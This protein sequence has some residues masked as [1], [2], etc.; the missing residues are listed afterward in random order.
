MRQP[1]DRNGAITFLTKLAE[2]WPRYRELGHVIEQR[3]LRDAEFEHELLV[4]S[5][6]APGDLLR[7]FTGV[8]HI[9]KIAENEVEFVDL[10]GQTFFVTIDVSNTRFRATSM[11][12]ECPACFGE[13]QEP[14]CTICAGVGKV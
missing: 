1:L 6:I 10:T 13:P 7:E 5:K 14:I 8:R 12:I 9:V 11:R 3:S 4:D 2:V